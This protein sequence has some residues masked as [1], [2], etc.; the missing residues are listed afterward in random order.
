MRDARLSESPAVAVG[1]ATHVTMRDLLCLMI[2]L[3]AEMATKEPREMK[4]VMRLNQ[5]NAGPCAGDTDRQWWSV[6]DSKAHNPIY[7]CLS[8][9]GAGLDS[10]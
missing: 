5:N 8:I 9:F 4:T 10:T 2:N 3:D 6:P 7:R 1:S